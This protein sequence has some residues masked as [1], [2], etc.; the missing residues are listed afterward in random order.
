MQLNINFAGV[1]FAVCM[2]V[3]IE[4]GYIGE[5][6]HFAV[7]KWSFCLF[8]ISI[9]HVKFSLAPVMAHWSWNRPI[10]FVFGEPIGP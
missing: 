2:V 3:C 9:F 6:C 8:L 4:L 1:K 10:G 5:S 7:I